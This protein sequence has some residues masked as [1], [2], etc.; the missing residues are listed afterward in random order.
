MSGE[1]V[2][3]LLAPS[4]GTL[5]EL[6]DAAV[7]EVEGGVR[8]A[9]T[10]DSFVVR[11]MFFPGGSIGDLAVNGTIND[12]AMAGAYPIALSCGL[13]V[14][15][16]TELAVLGRV[17]EAIAAAASAAGVPVVTGDTKVVDRGSGDGVYVNTTGIRTVPSGADIRPR[18]AAVDDVVILSG[19][20]G[21]HGIAVMS[22]REG[23]DFGTVVESDTAPLHDLVAR[24]IETGA[25]LHMLRD[26]TRG[27]ATAALC[28]IAAAA[29]VGVEYDESAVLVP[30]AVEA[31]CSFLG[32]DPMSVANEGKL[33]AVVAAG[34][35]DRVLGAMHTHPLG[36]HARTIGRVV[37]DH[38][39]V[40]TAT[41]AL[42]A[43]RIVDLPLGE[44]LPRIC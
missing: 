41:T 15:E 26:P 24:M 11:P 18:R 31:A 35:A 17:V 33:I 39:G 27:G 29:D 5:G 28:E 44:Q 4:F 38:P 13:I 40:V 22:R 3:H 9:F 34:D 23:L 10:T 20:I 30:D 32:L 42:G 19:P 7:V 37:A 8:L 12:L 21:E 43:R 1:L 2:R 25:D 6:H 14:E 36:R 16:G